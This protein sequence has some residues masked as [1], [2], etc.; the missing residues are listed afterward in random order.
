MSSIGGEL[1]NVRQGP[2]GIAEGASVSPVSKSEWSLPLVMA[3]PLATG[4]G[5]DNGNDD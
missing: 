5:G 2:R 4:Q 1:F 3:V